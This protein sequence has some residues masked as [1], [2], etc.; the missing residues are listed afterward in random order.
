MGTNF[1]G[2]KISKM[3]GIVG[4]LNFDN[5]KIHKRELKKMTNR[6][7]HRG[8][9]GEG[10]WVF[11]NNQIGL[12][13]RRLAII[14][15]DK[16]A[17]QPMHF[18]DRYTI[19]FNGEIFNYLEIRSKLISKKYR[20]KTESDTEVLLA[21]YAE[22]GKDML[23][24]LDGMFAFA[25]WDSLKEELFCARDRF[26]EKPFFYFV[27][28]NRLVFASELKAIW[29]V[30]VKREIID[31]K[32]FSF[33]LD[34]CNSD[35]SYYKGISK[36]DPAHFIIVSKK[37]EM[38]ISRYWSLDSIEIDQ[39]IS[40][41]SAKTK[42]LNLFYKSIR[43][44]L[45]SDVTVGSSLSGGLDS[46]SIV[47]SVNLLKD[48]NQ[49]QKVF[50]ARFHNFNK[51]EGSFIDILLNQTSEIKGFNTWPEDH[52]IMDFVEKV[53]YHH[54]EPFSSTSVLAQWKLMELVKNNQVTVL[55]DGQGADEYLAGY[56]LENKIYFT[57]LFFENRI[58]YEEQLKKFNNIRSQN[59]K[60]KH[61]L[62]SESYR[63]RFGRIKRKILNQP[64]NYQTLKSSLKLR[65]R[66]TGFEN[67]LQYADRNSM[68][69]SRE[70]RLP[71][72]SH[73]LVE[74]IFSLPDNYIINDGW[75]KYIH[76]S[77]FND[78]LPSQICWRKEKVGFEPPQKRWLSDPFILNLI[79]KQRRYFNIKNTSK[80]NYSYVND[81]NW[82]LFISNFFQN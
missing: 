18:L 65:L 76:R 6:L 64:I 28:K 62:E 67:L 42:Y 46:S 55:L 61:Y 45:R 25:I 19:T 15:L 59:Q 14:D 43:L 22:M 13:H 40:F 31:E 4:I 47:S 10:H 27:N 70:I 71:F 16:R 35:Q 34:N 2:F 52:N 48:R 11:E 9:D 75:N 81:L 7:S 58:K 49:Q 20:F 32:I 74:F 21:L 69:F 78:K 30:G 38:K 24:Y 77:C 82:R 12:G 17:S 56:T 44:R 57:Q 79:E 1:L 80:E 8:P 72:L 39:D 53:V 60:I 68:A 3:C 54:E 63:M 50:S 66:S 51:D 73:E 37:G 36:L 23:S 41:D 26:G 29:E 5:K 33:I